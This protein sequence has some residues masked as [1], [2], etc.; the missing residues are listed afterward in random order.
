MIQAR[1]EAARQVQRRRFEGTKLMSN[2]GMGPAEVREFCQVDDA[3]A[4][5][6]HR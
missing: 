2:A 1:V 5:K 3:C 4:Q 6:Q